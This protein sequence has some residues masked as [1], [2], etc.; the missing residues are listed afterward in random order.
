MKPETAEQ[1]Y[2]FFEE[3]QIVLKTLEEHI[4]SF[5]QASKVFEKTNNDFEKIEKSIDGIGVKIAEKIQVNTIQAYLVDAVKELENVTKDL[6]KRKHEER[7]TLKIV[8]ASTCLSALLTSIVFI[9]FEAANK[10]LLNLIYQFV[11]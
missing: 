7:S 11:H 1:T 3:A 5:N 10:P 4:S 6:K 8:F 9:A 2:Q